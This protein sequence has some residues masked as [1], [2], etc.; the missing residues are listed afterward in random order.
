MVPAKAI[1]LANAE[2]EQLEASP[3]GG[4]RSP[5]LILTPAQRYIAC[6]KV[7]NALVVLFTTKLILV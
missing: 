3:R 2:V 6:P 5:Y 4:H 1:E 7:N